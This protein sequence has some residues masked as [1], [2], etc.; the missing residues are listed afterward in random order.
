[1]ATPVDVAFKVDAPREVI[2]AYSNDLRALGEL[3]PGVVSIETGDDLKHAMWHM[4]IKLGMMKIKQDLS[5]TII[6]LEEPRYAEF[7]CESHDL[8]MVGNVTLDEEEGTTAIVAH[9]EADGQGP[10]RKMIDSYMEPKLKEYA[11]GFAENLKTKVS[12]E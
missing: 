1:M 10:L 8:V 2:F 4:Q 12:T 11:T 9:F 5:T 6:A 7:R 3:V